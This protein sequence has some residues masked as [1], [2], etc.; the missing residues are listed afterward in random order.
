MPKPIT[1]TNDFHNTSATV[2]PVPIKSGRFAGYHKIAWKTV[3]R[4]RRE[5]CGRTGCKC[6]GQF[7]ERGGAYLYVT[8]EDEFGALIINLG[9]SHV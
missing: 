2:R 4:L 1:L 5:L 6:G 8:N 3:M 9:A 7:G